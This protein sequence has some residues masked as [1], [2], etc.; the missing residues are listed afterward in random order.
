VND[1]EVSDGSEIVMAVGC[2][3]AL[4]WGV[5]VSLRAFFLGPLA[6]DWVEWAIQLVAGI[7][8]CLLVARI[9]LLVADWHRKRVRPAAVRLVETP[10]P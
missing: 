4:L 8:V 7:A 9:A 3:A 6:I 10:R 2:I 1:I 5:G